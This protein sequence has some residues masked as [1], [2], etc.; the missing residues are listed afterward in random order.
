MPVHWSALVRQ[1]VAETDDR[2]VNVDC[3][4][5]AGNLESLGEA[6]DHANHRVHKIDICD[7]R[8][9]EDV[10]TRSART[11]YSISRQSRSRSILDGPDTLMQTNWSARTAANAVAAYWNEH[12]ARQ[13]APVSTS[14]CLDDTKF[15]DTGSPRILH[16][17]NPVRS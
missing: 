10:F 1:L 15:R 12:A 2:I 7:V 17:E 9:C 13:S 11:L 5:Y 4:T 6:R 8:R 3:L 16:R 14:A